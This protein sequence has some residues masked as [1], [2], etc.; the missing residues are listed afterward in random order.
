MSARIGRPLLGR[1]LRSLG[2]SSVAS[3]PRE[4]IRAGVGATFGLGVLGCL[5][6]ASGVHLHLGLYLIA[7]FGATTV[8]VFAAP[9]SPL[10]QPWPTV[11][12]SALSAAIGVAV[13]LLIGQPT[14]RVAV[15]VGLAVS[16][17]ILCRAVHPPAGAVAMSAALAPETIHALGFWFVLAPVTVGACV[18]VV[19][20]TAY[21]RA[22]GRHYPFRQF[23]AEPPAEDRLGLS[24]AEL[25]DI[26]ARYRQSL[27]LG[28]ADLAR[29]IGAAELQAAGHRVEPLDA[30]AIMSTDLITVGPEA[31]ASELAALF[32]EHGFTSLPVVR[33]DGTF[34]GMVSDPSP[35]GHPGLVGSRSGRALATSANRDPG[36]RHHGRRPP[37]GRPG[38]VGGRAAPA[39]RRAR[40]RRDAGARRTPHRRHRDPHRP[41]RRPRT[42]D[43]AAGP[44]SLISADVIGPVSRR[45]P[46]PASGHTAWCD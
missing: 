44:H 23:D 45:S 29:L 3:S 46:A 19:L 15:A 22:T 41:H 10:A 4:A 13:T 1:I 37:G 5:L 2:P 8:L 32:G 21:G 26:L 34:A 20:A 35:V 18:L 43:V 9:S 11:V 12:G 40:L 17:M 38:L 33:P 39:A 36:R 14:I 42:A 16:A 24:E 7:P 31:T 30:A 6:V 27:N 25:T 28:V